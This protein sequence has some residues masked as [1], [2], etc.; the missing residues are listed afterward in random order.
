MRCPY[1]DSEVESGDP[2][3]AMCGNRLSE[4]QGLLR[5]TNP[6][7]ILAILAITVIV[8]VGGGIIL[9]S[10]ARPGLPAS[11]DSSPTITRT[12]MPSLTP[13]TPPAPVLWVT[14]TGRELGFSLRY[15][16]DWLV[17][18]DANRRQVVFALEPDDLQMEDFLSGTGFAVVVDPAWASGTETPDVV[19]DNLSGRLSSAYGHLQYGQ[20]LSLSIDGAEAALMYVEGEFSR[21]GIRLKSRVAAAVAYQHTY[22]F[23]ATA[24]LEDWPEREPVFREMLD[25]VQLSGP[26]TPAPTLSPTPLPSAMP[27]TPTTVSVP[28]SGPDP[29]EPDDSIDAVAPVAADGLPQMH[30]LHVEGDHDYLCFEAAAGKAYTIETYDLG[31]DIDPIIYLYD[32]EGQELAH[33]DDGTA[34]PLASRIVWLAPGSGVYCV[35]VRD[36]GEDSAGIDAR[37][38]LTV[39]ESAFAAGADPYEPDD[40]P[41]EATPIETDGTRQ[42]HT[43]HTTT[44]VDYVSFTAQQG[45]EYTIQTGDLQAACDTVIYLYDEAGVELDYDDD[46]GE[47][48]FASLIVW[49]APSTGV[50]YVRIRDF[51]GRAGPA[52][53]YDVWISVQ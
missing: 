30:N 23:L 16:E 42:P 47:D 11:T 45:R 36:L 15:P 31:S 5:R 44:D 10:R 22:V 34:E 39:V 33:N 40:T 49:T 50:Y 32:R 20:V 38:S 14:H 28:P 37:Y 7:S 6:L 19:L 27:V 41:G 2:Y 48:S 46:A 51:S 29:F 53:S 13:T 21:P 24:P 12:S 9:S 35:M 25:S 52:V 18:E 1:C 17:R 4:T 8:C 43:F 3:C 26:T